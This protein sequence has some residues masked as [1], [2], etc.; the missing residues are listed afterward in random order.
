[1]ML[2][3]SGCGIGS[4][5]LR[6]D[7]GPL[8]GCAGGPHCVSSTAAEAGRQIA[9]LRF[10]VDPALA[11]AILVALVRDQSRATVI[12]DQPGYVH[13]EFMTPLMRFV[14]DAEFVIHPE[15]TI[16]MRSASRIGYYD[17]QVNRNR[18]EQLRAQFDARHP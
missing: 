2:M 3:T 13:A 7:G 14:D 17:F 4:A 5:Q 15:G 10:T 6:P 18:L 1:M 11:Q 16:D 12:T 8:Q 9:P